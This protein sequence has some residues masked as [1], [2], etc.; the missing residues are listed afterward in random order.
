MAT[1]KDRKIKK[2]Q[3]KSGKPV[4]KAIAVKKIML[5]KKAAPVYLPQV[6]SYEEELL[7]SIIANKKSYKTTESS[8][9]FNSV[10]STITPGIRNLYYRSGVSVGRALY[11]LYEHERKY[12][13]YEESVADL[14]AF[15]E[16]AGFKGVTYNVF[17]DKIDIQ[18]HNTSNNYLGT[19]IHV[20]ES[21]LIC[22]FLTAGK[23]QHVRVME[24]SC[25]SNG[26]D[27]CHFV[28]SDELP[29][30]LDA[31][32]HEVIDRFVTHARSDMIRNRKSGQQ[33]AEEYYALS[34]SV[35][36]DNEY[37]DHINKVVY[38]LGNQIGSTINVPKLS[39][40]KGSVKVLEELFPM[41]NLGDL[42]IKSLKPLNAT[43]RFDRLKAKK[44][45]VDISITFLQ[46][47]LKHSLRQDSALDVRTSRK[48][49]SYI[50]KLTER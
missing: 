41:F 5:P 24:T 3:K 6:S 50:A 14:V 25:R 49:N 38:Y 4:R 35:F 10:L 42:S 40:T 23:Q 47:L 13:W 2:I 31:N 33:I 11:R 29:L 9:T 28:T 37:L 26:A 21:G 43:I 19:D 44:E 30:Y 20:F 18:F 22:G 34:S 32:G 46:G 15:F 48:N 8:L 7:K 36:T 16:K 27:K 1:K 39:H 17:P 45:F 12:L